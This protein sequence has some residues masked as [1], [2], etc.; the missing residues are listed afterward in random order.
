ML[1]SA[2]YD[3]ELHKLTLTWNKDA[4]EK[5]VT[6]IDLKDLIDIYYAGDGITISQ[7]G[8]IAL[9]AEA[10]SNLQQATSAIQTITTKGTQISEDEIIPS[11]LIAT[12][13]EENNSYDIAI[14]DSITFIFNCGNSGVT[15]ETE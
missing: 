9:T 7:E 4:G 12:K 2:T 1:D 10:K 15:S 11:G 13:D 6:E 8:V 14:D 3:K 5:D